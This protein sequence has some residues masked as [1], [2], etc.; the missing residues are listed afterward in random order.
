MKLTLEQLIDLMH[1]AAT[2]A[3]DILAQE[4]PDMEAADEAMEKSEKYRTRVEK[5][6]RARTLLDIEKPAP[7]ATPAL[8]VVADEADKKAAA[9]PLFK[10]MGD[11]L[12]AVMREDPRIAPLRSDDPLDE[13]AYDVGKAIG[14]ER[15]GSLYDAR[16]ASQKKAI[17]G[18]SEMVPADGG[19]LVQTDTQTSILA[20]TYNIGQL[21]QR[22]SMMPISNTAN[23]MTLYGEAETSRATGSR[24]GGVRA[25]WASEGDEKTSSKPTFREINLKLQKL[26]GLVYATDELLAD[27]PALEAYI[28][29]RLPEELRFL[30]ENAILRGTG[31]GQ[32]LGVLNAGCL[33]SQAA[34]AGQAA[35][36]IVAENV[37]NMWSRRWGGVNDY[38]WLINQDCTPQLF[39]MNLPV[40]TSGSLVYMPP[41]GLSGAPYGTLYGRP[42]LEM[43]YCSTLGTVG[44][45]V[46]FSPSEYQMIDKGG[47]Q[48]AV[49]IHVRFL[50][51]EQTF[52]F[53][54][55]IDG[56]PLWHQ[57]LT[58][59]QGTV[60]QSPFVALAS[61]T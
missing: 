23:S 18:M 45:I 55:R 57:P 38:V 19:I 51:D 52:R 36:T 7:K 48:S 43:E 27:A 26:I 22:V 34:E 41:G 28:M 32:P 58:P 25:Y 33:V 30:A 6:K 1:E 5:M 39:Q 49:S 61:R 20:R 15:V 42:V 37:I 53:V 47:I 29:Q 9:G 14:Q 8:T 40:G 3:T 60:T 24:R 35:T 21:L 4:S 2:E 13:R 46:L 10:S 50:Y 17:S 59:F 31:A 44:D 16:L 12:L 11:F 56:Q 54:M